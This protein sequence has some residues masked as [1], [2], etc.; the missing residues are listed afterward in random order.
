MSENVSDIQDEDFNAARQ[1]CFSILDNTLKMLELDCTN[2]MTRSHL[3]KKMKKGGMAQM[4][5]SVALMIY[6]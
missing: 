5:P 6:N 3:L 4:T 2:K 1:G